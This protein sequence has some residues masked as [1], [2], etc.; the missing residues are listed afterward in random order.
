MITDITTSVTKNVLLFII[1]YLKVWEINTS[2]FSIV[3]RAMDAAR[4][5]KVNDP[6][7]F[8]HLNKSLT[9]GSKLMI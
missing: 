7:I 2:D 6:S 3:G 9:N 1:Y 5:V 8:S 4:S